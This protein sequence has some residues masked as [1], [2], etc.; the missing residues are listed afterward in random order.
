M[1]GDRVDTVS[2]ITQQRQAS[3]VHLFGQSQSQRIDE[4]LPDDLDFAQE[5]AETPHQMF[6]KQ[7]VADAEQGACFFMLFRPDDA[8]AVVIER[9]DGERTRRQEMFVGDVVMRPFHLNGRHHRALVVIP[10]D[11][12]DAGLVAQRTAPA[13]G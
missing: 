2:G 8:G 12:A 10:V 7:T 4:F 1:P 11:M 3:F 6:V 5:F 9:Q 13:F